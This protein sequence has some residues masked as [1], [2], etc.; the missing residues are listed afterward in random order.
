MANIKVT[1]SEETKSALFMITGQGLVPSQVEALSEA[2]R[3]LDALM[4]ADRNKRVQLKNYVDEII[5]TVKAA[6]EQQ[7]ETLVEGDET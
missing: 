6:D 2:V 1:I 7:D 3:L 4:P 5:A